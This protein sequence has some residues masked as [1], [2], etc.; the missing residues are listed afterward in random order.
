MELLKN[1]IGKK[2]SE[3]IFLTKAINYVQ[4]YS[5]GNRFRFYKFVKNTNEVYESIL[6]EYE[7]DFN[8]ELIKICD[9]YI[10]KEHSA[11][12]SADIY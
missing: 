10:H 4:Q 9:E 2:E 6:K 7:K 1:E 12:T 11:F 5:E 8:M 3:Y